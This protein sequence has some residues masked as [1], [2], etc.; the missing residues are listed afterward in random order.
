[1]NSKGIIDVINNEKKP[2]FFQNNRI[3][4]IGPSGS[5]KSTLIVNLVVYKLNKFNNIVIISPSTED[6]NLNAL[7]SLALKAKLNVVWGSPDQSGNLYIPIDD[8]EKQDFLDQNEIINLTKSLFIID[9]L[10]SQKSMPKSLIMLLEI[11]FIRSRHNKNSVIYT[12][13]SSKNI[14]N[15]VKMGCN[16]LFIEREYDNI[17][18][19]NKIKQSPHTWYELDSFLNPSYIKEVSFKPMDYNKVIRK[20]NDK[21]FKEDIGKKIAD[22]KDYMAI[23]LQGNSNAI[24]TVKKTL[25]NTNISEEKSGGKADFVKN[26]YMNKTK[27]KPKYNIDEILH[28]SFID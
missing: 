6:Q 16:S 5:G 18:L 8:S 2:N 14:P 25:K 10:Y 7:K 4:I 12:C 20:L 17:P 21:I 11:L 15:A 23:G 24:K 19:S 13:H 26:E 22:I 3:I 28:D 1:M 9:D 27:E